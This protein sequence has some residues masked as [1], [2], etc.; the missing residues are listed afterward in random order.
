LIALLGVAFL[1]LTALALAC[2]LALRQ[3]YR[4]VEVGRHRSR[5]RSLVTLQ[6]LL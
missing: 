6:F 5:G 2:A 3:F 4:D 1:G